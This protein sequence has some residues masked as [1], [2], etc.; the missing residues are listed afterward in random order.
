MTFGQFRQGATTLEDST[1]TYYLFDN[2]SSTLAPDKVVLSGNVFRK[3]AL[4]TTLNYPEANMTKRLT[5]YYCP[6]T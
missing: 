5:S 3:L 1:A 2:F 6:L 4:T